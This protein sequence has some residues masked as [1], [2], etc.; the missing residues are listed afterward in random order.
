MQ[1]WIK[2]NIGRLLS[3]MTKAEDAISGGD[4]YTNESDLDDRTTALETAVGMPYTSETNISTRLTNIETAQTSMVGDITSI[5][6]ALNN[7]SFWKG[8]ESAYAAITT[9]AEN[10]LY[11]CYADPVTPV[12]S[13]SKKKG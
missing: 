10:T 1:T 12:Q 8:T 6:T 3:R 11:L 5:E 2:A 4:V 13:K 7:V 9:P